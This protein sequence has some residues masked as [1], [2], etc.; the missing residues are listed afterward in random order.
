MFDV[1]LFLMLTNGKLFNRTMAVLSVGW[2]RVEMF[3]IK[4]GN[5][6]KPDHPILRSLVKTKVVLVVFGSNIPLKE[7]SK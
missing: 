7:L 6:Q 3:Y 5:R 1:H 2:Y 4:R